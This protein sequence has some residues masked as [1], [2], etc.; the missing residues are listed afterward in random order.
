[1]TTLDA[2]ASNSISQRRRFYGPLELSAPRRK[3]VL[4]STEGF[5]GAVAGGGD[6]KNRTLTI[7]VV[8]WVRAALDSQRGYKT[9]MNAEKNVQII[10]TTTQATKDKARAR[11]FEFDVSE[12]Q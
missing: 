4:Y 12:P 1:M 6:G 2:R 7:P 8:I 3:D 9:T 11:Q 10:P 5:S